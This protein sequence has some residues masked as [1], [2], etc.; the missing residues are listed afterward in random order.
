MNLSPFL[1]KASVSTVTRNLW[2]QVYFIFENPMNT[3]FSDSRLP[4]LNSEWKS[5]LFGPKGLLTEVFHFVNEK[6]KQGFE[7]APQADLPSTP[8]VDFSKVFDA[9]LMKSGDGFDDPKI[10]EL[11]FIGIC[12]RVNCGDIYKAV[13][14]FKKS[15]LFSNFQT[16]LSLIQDPKG[17]DIIEQALENPELIE[18]FAGKPENI[19]QLLG[20]AGGSTKAKASSNSHSMSIL[21]SD[22]DLGIDFTSEI[23]P[24]PIGKP[25]ISA[26][27]DGTDYYSA[28]ETEKPSSS[29]DY[30]YESVDVE[31]TIPPTTT[32]RTTTTTEASTKKTEPPLPELSFSV[33]EAVESVDSLPEYGSVVEVE[34]SVPI[35]T[36]SGSSDKIPPSALERRFVVSSTTTVPTT[37]TTLRTT[38]TS[39]RITPPRRTTVTFSRTTTTERPSTTTRKNFRKDNDYYSMYYDN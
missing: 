17:W 14:Q 34:E 20:K 30:D 7:N 31:E 22:G 19:G 1:R 27:I 2:L 8:Q 10:P 24:K 16:A 25:E 38:T 36:K 11:P 3:I 4:P 15:E 18:Q 12:N 35:D 33:D 13:D 9:I 28:V 32:T 37:T 29:K 5:T 6:R 39:R 23:E 26:N 21:P